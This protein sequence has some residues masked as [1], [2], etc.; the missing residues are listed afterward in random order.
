MRRRKL[1]LQEK[2]KFLLHYDFGDDW[3]FTINVE[4]INKTEMAILPRVIKQK[5]EI[6]QYPDVDDWDWEDE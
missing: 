2:Q 6:E 3:L 5:G 4:K 1:R